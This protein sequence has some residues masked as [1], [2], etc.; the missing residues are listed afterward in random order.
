M[1]AP[2]SI[3][4]CG[5]CGLA[6][7]CLPL[8]LSQPEMTQL[9]GIVARIKASAYAPNESGYFRRTKYDVSFGQNFY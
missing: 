1:N 3:Q 8:G 7:M 9:D 4:S 5:N 2:M 6:S